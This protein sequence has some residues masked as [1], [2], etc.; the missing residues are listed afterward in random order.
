VVVFLLGIIALLLAVAIIPEVVAGVIAY[1]A[2]VGLGGLWIALMFGVSAAFDFPGWIV[3]VFAFGVPLLWLSRQGRED[4]RQERIERR[5]AY[6]R[7]NIPLPLDLCDTEEE[8]E[9]ANRHYSQPGTK[10]R[11]EQLQGHRA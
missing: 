11:L 2:V 5:A 3:A 1:A 8:K 9:L 6:Q 4:E 10:R 7:L